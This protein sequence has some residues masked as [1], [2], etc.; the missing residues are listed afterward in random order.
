[1]TVAYIQ[2]FSTP[3]NVTILLNRKLNYT[4][5]STLESYG[6]IM[7]NKDHTEMSLHGLLPEHQIDN[8]RSLSSVEGVIPS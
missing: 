7:S 6:F 8:V 4:I 2:E 3:V 5:L 1:M